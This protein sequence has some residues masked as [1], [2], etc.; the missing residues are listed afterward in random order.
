M[1]E[2]IAL[3]TQLRPNGDNEDYIADQEG[4]KNEFRFLSEREEFV[5]D[6][7]PI[8]RAI[9]VRHHVCLRGLYCLLKAACLWRFPVARQEALMNLHVGTE[10][11]LELMRETF[12][13]EEGERMNRRSIIRHLGEELEDGEHWALTLEASI[14]AWIETKHPSSEFGPIW[15]PVSHYIDYHQLSA[16]LGRV[17]RYVLIGARR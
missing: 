7:R 8:Y 10:A 17:F 2:P 14:E 3:L 16:A 15:S 1:T 5:V 12:Q 6:P 13:P 11:A 4:W 9:P